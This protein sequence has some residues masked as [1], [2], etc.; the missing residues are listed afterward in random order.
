M[1]WLMNLGF[2]AGPSIVVVIDGFGVAGLIDS[3]GQ[4]VGAIISNTG[5]GTKGNISDSMGVLGVIDV[6]GKGVK[7]DI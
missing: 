7:G 1:L 3:T 4:G 6:T 5:L 2:A